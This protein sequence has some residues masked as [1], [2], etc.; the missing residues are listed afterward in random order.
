LLLENC[1][2]IADGLMAAEIRFLSQIERRF[3]LSGSGLDIVKQEDA[4]ENRSFH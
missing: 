2:I 3:E 4:K 1:R